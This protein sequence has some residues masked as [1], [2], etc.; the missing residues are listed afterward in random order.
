MRKVRDP[1]IQAERAIKP[2]LRL[3]TPKASSSG[4]KIRSLGTLHAYRDALK[5]TATWLR[6]KYSLPL[7]VI[8]RE[9]A[10]QYLAERAGTVTQKTLD[11]DRRALEMHIGHVTK[12]S[13]FKLDNI[14]VTGSREKSSRTYTTDQVR[15]LIQTAGDRVA[16]SIK[17][18][19]LAGLRAHEL[20]TLQPIS[21]RAVTTKRT[22][23][24]NLYAGREDWERYTVVGKGG[25]IREV[26]LPQSVARSLESKRLATPGSIN[27]RSIKYQRHYD[28]IGGKK[29]S[30]RF[31]NLSFKTL[32]FSNGAHGLRHSYAVQRLT[33]L[34]N[35]GYTTSDAKLIVSQELGHFR[36]DV[37]EVYLR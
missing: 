21:E 8:D 11:R 29:F 13:K 18:A 6:D 3:N 37:V 30:T 19:R 26:R 14:G 27:D 23:S 36:K 31:S 25:L 1:A 32:G 20:H 34:I 16:L 17:I 4:T 28:L 5:M 24:S 33:E 15:D 35:K 2:L 9:K 7:K 10:I 22:W 12:D